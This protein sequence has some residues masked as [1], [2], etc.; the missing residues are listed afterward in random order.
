MLWSE[1]DRFGSLLDPWRE[2]ER[3]RRSLSRAALPTNGEF[4]AV[5]VWSAPDDAVVTTEIPG[6][7][8]KDIEISV[9]GK[10]L[11]VKGSRRPEE[12]KEGE[13]FHRRERW[14]GQFTRTFELPFSV[15]QDKVKARFSKGV[16]T[17]ELP[18][19]EKEKPKKIEIKSE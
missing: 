8:P 19:A 3:M 5:N 1:F 6:I 12:L 18:R 10:T 14:H 2:F 7:D 4:P 11:T 13:T 15:E 17:I 9:V 16:L